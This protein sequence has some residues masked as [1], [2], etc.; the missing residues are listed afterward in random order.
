MIEQS[1]QAPSPVFSALNRDMA[2][3]HFRA[4][5]Y[6]WQ[7]CRLCLRGPDFLWG[8]AKHYGFGIR[9]RWLWVNSQKGSRWV[10]FQKRSSPIEVVKW[11]LQIFLAEELQKRISKDPTILD[12]LTSLLWTVA[13]VAEN[14]MGG[15][16]GILTNLRN[17]HLFYK[18]HASI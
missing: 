8:N 2:T 1:D 4:N 13:D 16:S 18:R 7:V 3:T 9:R 6:L 14:T 15:S 12:H 17:V 11:F 10:P 5:I